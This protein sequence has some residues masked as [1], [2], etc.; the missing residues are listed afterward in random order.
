MQRP[1]TFAHAVDMKLQL[2][3]LGGLKL[4][5]GGLKLTGQSPG[6]VPGGKAPET[7]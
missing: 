6:G 4:T 7:Q 3:G 1:K 2:G 5:P